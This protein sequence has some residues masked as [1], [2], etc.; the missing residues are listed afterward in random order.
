VA[1]NHIK[2]HPRG[3]KTH[4]FQINKLSG[5]GHCPLSG[6]EE[7]NLALIRLSAQ[8]RRLRGD[9]GDRPLQ[10]IRW[11]MVGGGVMVGSGGAYIPS[12]I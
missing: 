9:S 4:H 5:Q 7:D 1:L 6:E 10:I 2:H 11:R 8:G 12:N 3:S